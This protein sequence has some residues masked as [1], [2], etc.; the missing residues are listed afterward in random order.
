MNE[1]GISARYLKNHIFFWV[2]IVWRVPNMI[3]IAILYLIT[4]GHLKDNLRES[5]SS[6]D[7]P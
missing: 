7:Y 5:A 2:I 6:S 4:M 3:G 1:V